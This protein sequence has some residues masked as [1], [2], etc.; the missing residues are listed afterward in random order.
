MFLSG[1]KPGSPAYHLAVQAPY[2][3]RPKHHYTVH[4]RAVPS[5]CQKHRITQ[6]VVFSPFKSFQNLCPVFALPIYLRC[7]KPFFLQDIP[8]LL[9]GLYQRKKNHRLPVPA[10][11]AHLIGNLVQI[12]I[13]CGGDIPGFEIS[14]L[15]GHTGQVQLQRDRQRLDRGKVSFP[16]RL[17]QRIFISQTVEYFPQVPHVSPVRSSG[18]AQHLRV[19]EM[20]QH[21]LITVRNAMMGFID[22]NRP[23][24][25]CRKSAKP[26]F[27]H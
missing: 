5:F 6:H 20:P 22:N 7:L 21:F 25:I 15:H 10:V 8:K 16:D 2:L 19:F 4:G 17:R 9:A 26:L 14:G 24:V 23:E 18:Y 3:C 12:R 27:P 13:Q 11:F 1:I